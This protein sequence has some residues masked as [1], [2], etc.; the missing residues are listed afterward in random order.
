MPFRHLLS[1]LM[2]PLLL[3]APP[4]A[5][6]DAA[7][8]A[9]EAATGWTSKPLVEA[10]DFMVA[11][12]HPLAVEAGR[13]VL[14]EGGSAVDAAVAVQLVL[15]LVEPQSSGIGG[16]AFM[17]YRDARE[18]VLTAYD[19]RETAPAEAGP[20]LFLTPEGAPMAFGD[21]VIGGR[22]VGT[23]G[24]LRL[25]EL[26]HRLHGRL[27]WERLFQP[28]IELAEAGFEVSP[29]LAAL[30]REEEQSLRR[31]PATSAYFLPEGR[32]V[33]AGAVLRNPDF[34]AVLRGVAERGADAFYRGDVARDIV[35][36]VRGAEGNPG[37]LSEADL[38]GYR[39]AVRA[40]VCGEYRAHAVCGMGPP[41]SGGLTLLQILGILEHFPLSSLD[42]LSVEATHLFAEASRLAYADRALYIADADFI[43]V[44]VDGLLDPGYLTLRAQL[45]DRGSVIGNPRAGNP[46]WREGRAYAPDASLELPST[47]HVSIVDG[48]GNVVSMTTTIEAGFGS[49]LMVRGFL[50]NNEL[51]DFSFVP[52]ADGRPVA[53]RVEPGKRPRSSMAPTIVFDAAGSPLLVTGSPGG[54]RII[55]YVARSVLGV[56]DWGMDA[57]QAVALPHAVSLG[58]G[59]DL[60]AGTPA[61]DLAPALEALGHRVGVRDLNSGLHA[62]ML[63]DGALTGGADPRREGVAL[64]E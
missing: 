50:L 48:D 39:V 17:L 56:V 8:P 35:A 38:A 9:P 12:A 6:Q 4:S 2:L 19:G 34:A 49:R 63:R 3:L 64:G 60:E 18:G 26:A 37:L 61:A 59:V 55:G 30:V 44:P 41:S 46:P 53:N 25:M 7:R 43:P 52:E 28:A 54:A 42:P 14:R 40:P 31:F 45:I 27:P 16:G 33:E 1:V 32:P 58:G 20:D 29:R 13:D 22:S 10:R 21:A 23:P 5:A 15:N 47:S 51:T 36:T 57:A 62:I 11:A 24:T